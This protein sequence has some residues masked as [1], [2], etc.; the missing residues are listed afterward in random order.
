MNGFDINNIRKNEGKGSTVK[1]LPLL[2]SQ[3]YTKNNSK[4]FKNDIK[5]LLKK[6]YNSKQIT[7][8]TYNNLIKAI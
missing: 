8:F 1:K 6:L 4:I 5:Q 7:K 2:L 3:L